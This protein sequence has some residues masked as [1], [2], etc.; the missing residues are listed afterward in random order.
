VTIKNLGTN[1]ETTVTTNDDGTYT[2][3]LLQ[4]GTYTISVA[5]KGFNTTTREEIEIRVA[6]KLTLDVQLQAEGL[7]GMVTVVSTQAL[8]TGS[9]STGSV[10][11]GRQISEL[12]LTEGTAYQ[13]ATLAPGIA[14]TGNPQFTAPISNGNLAAFR[15]NGAP[16][17]NQ[18]TLD[19]SPNYAFDGAV[20]FSP[21]ADA[22]QEFK[23][24]TN[25]FDGQQGYS[26]GATVN[27]AVLNVNFPATLCSKLI[28]LPRGATISR[29]PETWILCR[30][31][32]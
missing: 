18:I 19:G 1:G 23:I 16:P 32:F 28:T 17:Q 21:P 2:F 15:S 27:V 26:A 30:A 3:P 13:L 20:G 9:V 5:S 12:P 7:T 4:P 8:E 22:V 24:Q 29:S 10:I 6:D 31:H 11:D 14:Y 25:S